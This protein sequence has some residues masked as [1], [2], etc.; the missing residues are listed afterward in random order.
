MSFAASGEKLLTNLGSAFLNSINCG[1]RALVQR[2]K[3]TGKTLAAKILAAVLQTDVYRVDLPQSLIST[4]A[5][6]R[7]ISV[8]SWRALKSWT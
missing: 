2:A 6:Q 7:R 8:N 5:R 1:V 3:R 4:S